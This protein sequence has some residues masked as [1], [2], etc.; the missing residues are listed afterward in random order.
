M[1][2]FASRSAAL[3]TL[4]RIVIAGAG[5]P[6]SPA[7]ACE[8]MTVSDAQRRIQAAAE[9]HRI[10]VHVSDSGDVVLQHPIGQTSLQKA[11]LVARSLPYVRIVETF[12]EGEGLFFTR[13]I[14]CTDP[15]KR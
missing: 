15:E 5:E 7:R 1:T 10:R 4:R 8:R 2:G 9:V 6:D 11:H 12:R 3:D 13:A 14:A